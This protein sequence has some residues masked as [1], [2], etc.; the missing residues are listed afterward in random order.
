MSV[1]PAG[2]RPVSPAARVLLVVGAAVVVLLPAIVAAIAI[3]RP[4]WYP[5]GD[6][7]QAELHVRGFW[8][9]PPL[10]GAAGRIQSSA[11][12]QGSHPGPLLWA[13]MWPLYALLGSTSTA[14]VV[15]VVTVHVA[16]AALALW[17]ALRRGGLELAVAL[18]AALALIVRAGGPDQFTEPWNPWMGLLPFLVLLLACWSFLDGDRWAIVLAVA[19]GTYCVQAHTGYILIAGGLLAFVVGAVLVRTARQPDTSDEEGRRSPLGSTIVWIGV[20]AAAGLVLWIPPMLDQLRR[21]PGNFSILVDSFS[22]PDAPYLGVADVAK[23]AVVQLNVLGPWVLGAGRQDVDVVAVVGFVAFAALW[24]AGVV[25]ARRRR[26]VS[27]LRLHAVLAVTAVLGVVSV[28]RIFGLFLE[29]TVRW[30]W[31]LTATVVAA[32]A[33]SL[34]RTRPLGLARRAV[35]AVAVAVAAVVVIGAVRFADRAGPTGAI[36]SRIVGGLVPIVEPEL[37]KDTAY[38]VRWWDPTV[39]GATAFGMVLELERRGYEMGVDRP[40]AAAALPHRVL[41][42]GQAGAVLYVVVGDP[43][44]ER[45]RALPGVVELGSFDVRTPD[46]QR[47]SDELRAQLARAMRASGR[48]DQIALLDAPYGQAQLLF[49]NP[50][51]PREIGELL[52]EYVA[53]R[54]PTAVFRAPPFTPVLPLG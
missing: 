36:D 10:V 39:L 17:L 7:A 42:E 8:S 52:D 38:L 45:A 19:A 35:V 30:L 18:G 40:F 1:A 2:H 23:V 26:A 54:Q 4:Q 28:S 27:E 50:P 31:V 32:S 41:P 11:G 24:I 33:V 16:T 12:V 43:A 49:A 6:M 3:T 14:L 22:H 44:I 51:L 37:D 48:E 25:A 9:H 5:T 20:A 47:R 34:W 13:A 46:E 15:S 53:L 29:Y 21:E